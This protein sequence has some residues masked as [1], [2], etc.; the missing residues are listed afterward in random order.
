[1]KVIYSIVVLALLGEASAINISKAHNDAFD[2]DPDTAS[3]YDDQQ[4][5]SKPG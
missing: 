4:V 1:M 5:Y 3:V 2:R